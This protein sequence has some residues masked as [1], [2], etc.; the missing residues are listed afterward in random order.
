[1]GNTWTGDVVG[2]A[3]P[4]DAENNVLMFNDSVSTDGD[5][6]KTVEFVL[7]KMPKEYTLNLS[8]KVKTNLESVTGSAGNGFVQ[9]I[10]SDT[11][12]FPSSYADAGAGPVFG[13]WKG[14][15]I[16]YKTG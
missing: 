4:D 7:P 12:N 10:D 9:Y 15:G 16:C 8:Y 2:V 6:T 3:D 5:K 1:M 13:L 14:K 11:T